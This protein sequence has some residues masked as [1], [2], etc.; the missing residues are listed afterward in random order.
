MPANANRVQLNCTQSVSF[1]YFSTFPF[2]SLCG[3]W[4]SL[5][6]YTSWVFR[7]ITS[8]APIICRKF[9]KNICKIKTVRQT[10]KRSTIPHTNFFNLSISTRRL[11]SF[12]SILNKLQ[13]EANT[14]PSPT[15]P[16][17]ATFKPL[18][19]A[20]CTLRRLYCL[21]I[22]SNFL[23]TCAKLLKSVLENLQ[24]FA[25]TFSPIQ[26]IAKARLVAHQEVSN[27][28]TFILM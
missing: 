27:K 4:F 23:L 19:E 8:L 18:G 9:S 7:A 13:S 26:A 21:I 25:P 22:V 17:H 28:G 1:F 16:N 6:Y 11:T 15:L 12:A 24:S 20:C 5:F 10:P 14:K 3:L 2:D